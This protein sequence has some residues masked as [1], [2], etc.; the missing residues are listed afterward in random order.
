M[1]EDWSYSLLQ[2]PSRNTRITGRGICKF[3]RLDHWRMLQDFNRFVTKDR[4]HLAISVGATLHAVS[5]CFSFLFRKTG[6][7]HQLLIPN[8]MKERGTEKDI[9]EIPGRRITA[10]R[11][12]RKRGTSAG[13]IQK[14]DKGTRNEE[15]TD[16][17]HVAVGMLAHCA[18]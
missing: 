7:V 6:R 1:L 5:H 11:R 8:G 3:R 2:W 17:L 18:I 14:G 10:A 13:I 4:S 15:S 9:W 16:L 12:Q